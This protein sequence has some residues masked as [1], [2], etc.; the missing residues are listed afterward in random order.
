MGDDFFQVVDRATGQSEKA[1]IDANHGFGDEMEPV[2][3]E[4]VVG[5]VDRARLRIIERREA[6]VGATHLDRFEH[7]ANRC[8][9]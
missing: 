9:R 7:L 1:M 5:L 2:L 4:E 3:E 8:D 6:E